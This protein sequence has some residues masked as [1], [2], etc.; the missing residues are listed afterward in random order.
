MLDLD[1]AGQRV[2]LRLH[3]T[4][5]TRRRNA[6]DRSLI[7]DR[8]TDII[9]QRVGV[10]RIPPDPAQHDRSLGLDAIIGCIGLNRLEAREVDRSPARCGGSLAN[11]LIDLIF[12]NIV[13]EAAVIGR[14]IETVART[15]RVK[16]QLTAVAFFQPK[17]RIA[18]LIGLRPRM[19][20]VGKQFLGRW[21]AFGM[22]EVEPDADRIAHAVRS[23][24]RT[25]NRAEMPLCTRKPQVTRHGARGDVSEFVA[26]A[27]FGL[28]RAKI[29][30][31]QREEAGLVGFVLGQKRLVALH[32]EHAVEELHARG[33]LPAA[34][35]GLDEFEPAFGAIVEE[36]RTDR[37][38]GREFEMAIGGMARAEPD[39]I[40]E[41]A[42]G[43]H[44]GPQIVAI[45]HDAKPRCILP[46]AGQRRV[47]DRHAVQTVIMAVRHAERTGIGDQRRPHPGG[48]G[49][50]GGIGQRAAHRSAGGIIDRI[51]VGRVDREQARR[52]RLAPPPIGQRIA[53]N[54]QIVRLRIRTVGVNDEMLPQRDVAGGTNRPLVRR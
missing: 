51:G 27:R 45:L 1:A 4:E 33:T 39:A 50:R 2:R 35:L 5:H 48:P 10:D 53:A 13:G 9:A 15:V 49:L 54:P 28:E 20:T 18:Q 16:R 12:R 17:V 34:T 46:F 14:R 32:V 25:R 23:A 11:R 52:E 22:R 7:A 40:E 29:E 44:L 38:V 3:A 41:A 8:R 24:D 26:H 36:C 21:C 31:L 43:L 37:A 6:R 19:C 47:A 42:A 30:L